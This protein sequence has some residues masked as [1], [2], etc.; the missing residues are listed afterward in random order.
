[1]IEY[2]KTYLAKFLPEGLKKCPNKKIIDIYFPASVEHPI[3]RL[4]QSGDKYEITKKVSINPNDAGQQMEHNITLSEA[5][6]FALAAAPGK[7]VH[8]IRYYYDYQGRTAEVDIFLDDLTGLV[9][10]DV[11]FPSVAEKDAFIMP[12]FCLV[13]VTQDEFVTG[14][15]LCGKKYEDLKD[16]LN[17][18]GYK[19]LLPR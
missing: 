19:K 13:D 17:K 5:E 8:K 2:E 18:Y 14:G 9:V 7:G 10:I 4:R 15:M 11:E 3:L 6:F 1:M 12:E 16:N